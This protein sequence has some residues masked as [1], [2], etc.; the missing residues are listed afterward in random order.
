M[1]YSKGYDWQEHEEKLESKY[2]VSQASSKD[3]KAWSQFKNVDL[4]GSTESCFARP[5]IFD[6][7]LVYSS[8]P[9]I[10]FRTRNRGYRLRM[11]RIAN[12]ESFQE[13]VLIWDDNEKAE[14]DAAYAKFIRVNDKEYFF[15]NSDGFGRNGFSIASHE[16]I[17]LE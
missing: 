6:D 12:L 9:A 5:V 1:Y 10:D 13:C 16:K 14:K 3:G 2:L 11:G 15:Y 17:C 4:P 8:R 7:H